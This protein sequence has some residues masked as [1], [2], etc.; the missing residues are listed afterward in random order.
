[1]GSEVAPISA[2]TG[3]KARMILAAAP[4]T[5]PFP[6]CGAKLGYHKSLGITYANSLFCAT[7]SYDKVSTSC[8][9]CSW[10][11]SLNHCDTQNLQV[12]YCEM[13]LWFRIIYLV[14]VA[15]LV[16]ALLWCI[17]KY[18]CPCFYSI[19]ERTPLN[20]SY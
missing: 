10:M 20:R 16:L 6:S 5:T 8:S 7:G 11:G 2:D 14:L 1:M 3:A 9:K 15:M 18:C 19:C 4:I 17:C 13:N 12:D